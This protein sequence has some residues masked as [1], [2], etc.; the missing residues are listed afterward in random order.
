MR[1]RSNNK[2]F[3]KNKTK[4]RL[5]RTAIFRPRPP[6]SLLSKGI[7]EV[8]Y[9]DLSLLRQHLGMEWKIS[10]ARINSVSARMQRQIKTA[11][12]RARY[13]SLL[14]YTEHHN[15]GGKR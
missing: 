7:T 13:L 6:C 15:L 10:P 12:K 1:G 5:S 9:K 11:V 8:D 14:P 2:R 3:N 4:Q